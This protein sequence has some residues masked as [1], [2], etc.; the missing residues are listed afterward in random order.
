[1]QVHDFEIGVQLPG[2]GRHSACSRGCNPIER[3][4]D[5]LRH[6]PKK[7]HEQYQQS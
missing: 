4:L 6:Q 3:G 5:Q 7:H 2:L 1:M